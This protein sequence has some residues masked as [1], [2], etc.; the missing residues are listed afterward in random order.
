MKGHWETFC[1]ETLVEELITSFHI[2]RIITI[3]GNTL[4]I[5]TTNIIT[6]ASIAKI[7]IK[8]NK[9]GLFILGITTDTL[10]TNTRTRRGEEGKT[11]RV[12][13]VN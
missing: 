11:G 3:M 10:S 2:Q 1:L 5:T 6:M 8:K 12:L 7:I 9:Q 4:R 13:W